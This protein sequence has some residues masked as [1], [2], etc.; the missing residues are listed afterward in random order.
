MQN[1]DIPKA[2][3]LLDGKPLIR[4]VLDSVENS[5]IGKRPVIVIGWQADKAKKELGSRFEYIHQTEQLG[6]GHAV[7]S[8]RSG[9]EHKAEHL[10]VL[11][12]DM[13]FISASTIAELARVHLETQVPLTMA[14][15]SVEDF[16]DWRRSFSGFGRVVRNTQGNILRTVETKDATKEELVI[17]ECN[18]C[19]YCF[20][21]D[22]L[23]R[24]LETLKNDNAQGEYYLTDLVKIAVSNG[25]DIASIAIDP[26]EAIGINTAEDLALAYKVL[27]KQRSL[28]VLG[29]EEEKVA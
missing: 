12:G 27:I 5:G 19:Y 17:K 28:S 24:N 2:L 9:L 26:R 20:Q 22:W 14:T 15:C 23:W 11:Y 4:Y 10:I 25:E 1:K 13:P 8:A 21:A 3:T 16:D 29:V 18:P 6:T 7:R